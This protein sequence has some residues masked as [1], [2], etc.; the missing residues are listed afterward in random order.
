MI[1]EKSDVNDTFTSEPLTKACGFTVTI[2]VT[3]TVMNLQFPHRAVGPEEI[4]IRN[5]VWVAQTG[6]NTVRFQNVGMEMHLVEPGG[7]EIIITT[8]HHPPVLDEITGV[9]K[10]DSETG[11]TILESHKVSD[12]Q[13]ICQ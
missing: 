9:V 10:I 7:T 4:E 1:R 5:F 8:G 11:K 6:K 2:N 12:P 13:R 3:G